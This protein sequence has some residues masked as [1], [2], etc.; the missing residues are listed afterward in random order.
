MKK[1]L[2]LFALI[3]SNLLT[4]Q[5]LS[6]AELKEK[7]KKEFRFNDYSDAINSLEE[8]EKRFG[9]S[10]E[11]KYYKIVVGYSISLQDIRKEKTTSILNQ[12]KDITAQKPILNLSEA[13]INNL[14]YF[15]TMLEFSI[16]YYSEHRYNV[17]SI[18][19]RSIADVILLNSD[20]FLTKLTGAHKQDVLNVK[21][22]VTDNYDYYT[23]EQKAIGK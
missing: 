6:E 23:G 21:T 7:F 2:L 13:R 16:L 14:N 3:I 11:T 1:C 22:K 12:I 20:Q 8:I 15:K 9:S 4:A 19:R 10:D 17:S 5:Q 18:K